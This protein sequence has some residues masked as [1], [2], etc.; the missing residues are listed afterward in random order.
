MGGT[1]CTNCSDIACAS[2]AFY[3]DGFPVHESIKML[4]TDLSQ[5]ALLERGETWSKI[6]GVV[7]MYRGLSGHVSC[8]AA[9]IWMQ[10]QIVWC[11][12]PVKRQKPKPCETKALLFTHFSLLV[13]RN[14]WKC[15]NGVNFTLRF[16]WHQNVAIRVSKVH[17]GDGRHC[18]EIRAIRNCKRSAAAKRA[19]KIGGLRGWFLGRGR[20]RGCSSIIIIIIIIIITESLPS[21]EAALYLSR[22]WCR[23][24]AS[25]LKSE[26]FQTGC[27]PN[28]SDACPDRLKIYHVFPPIKASTEISPNFPAGFQ[29]KIPRQM[30]SKDFIKEQKRHIP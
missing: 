18:G 1:A 8:D 29:Y 28:L 16:V 3:L 19:T 24:I 4:R 2:C 5:N 13:V 23:G 26:H 20:R 15:L 11:E 21:K 6:V 25:W 7:A 27:L 10:I 9:A 12:R 22:I 14:R 17:S 30:H